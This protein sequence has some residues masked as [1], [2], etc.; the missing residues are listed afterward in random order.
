MELP[1]GLGRIAFLDPRSRPFAAPAPGVVKSVLY[2]HYGDWLNQLKTSS[3]TGNALAQAGNCKP[4]HKPRAK[5][6]EEDTALRWYSRAT[7]IDPFEGTYYF[8]PINGNYGD[9]SGSDGNSV[10]KAAREQGV[11][12]SWNHAFGLDHMLRALQ[13]EEDGGGGRPVI[14]GTDWFESMFELDS[15]GFIDARGDV[16]GGHEW[17]VFGVNMRDAYFWAGQSWGTWG[18]LRGKFKVPFATMDMLLK[19][20]GDVIQPIFA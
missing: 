7:A 2:T 14:V 10:C 20:D 11:V 3:C 6:F 13:R 18:P 17:L 8:P 5:K 1:F 15:K 4:N 9:D 16:V 19:R 12:L